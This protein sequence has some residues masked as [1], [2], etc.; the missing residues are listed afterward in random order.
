MMQTASPRPFRVLALIALGLGACASTPVNY[1]TLVASSSTQPTNNDAAQSTAFAFDLESVSVPLQVDQ[2]QLVVRQSGAAMAL[3]ETERWI[4]PLADEVRGALAANLV[5]AHRGEDLSGLPQG[6][7]PLVRIRVDVRRFDS[8]PGVQASITAAWSLRRAPGDTPALS[9]SS[10][11]SEPVGA[12]YNALVQGHQRALAR[13]ATAIAKPAA[14][15]AN[16]SSPSC[17]ANAG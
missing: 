4:A 9:C 17:P 11:F 7:R 1:Y 3:V 16:G 8:Q 14:A 15:M 6:Q 13:L 5:A 10:H 12:G 2:P